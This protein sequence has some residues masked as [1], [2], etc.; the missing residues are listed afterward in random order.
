[1]WRQERRR[2]GVDIVLDP[3]GDLDDVDEKAVHAQVDATAR[4]L[5]RV[6]PGDTDTA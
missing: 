2:Q 6:P 4:L 1:V 3:F 5:E